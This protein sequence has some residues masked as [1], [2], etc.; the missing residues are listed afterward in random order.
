MAPF[1]VLTFT[2]DRMLMS[3]RTVAGSPQPY[4]LLW[5]IL[6]PALKEQSAKVSESLQKKPSV[7]EFGSVDARR[8]C[9]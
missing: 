5:P 2:K 4:D 7:G 9:G 6:R 1:G 3:F 8:Q